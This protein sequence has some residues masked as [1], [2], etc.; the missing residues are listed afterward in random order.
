MNIVNRSSIDFKFPV[1][2]AFNTKKTQDFTLPKNREILHKKSR[3]SELSNP[4]K[5]RYFGIRG[6][7]N[8]PSSM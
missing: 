7:P 3:D 4:E 6:F 8:F 5:F 1:F 2:S